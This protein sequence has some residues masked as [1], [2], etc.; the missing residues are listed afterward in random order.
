[1]I[2]HSWVCV[3]PFVY[4]FWF[5][6]KLIELYQETYSQQCSPIGL[7]YLFRTTT[8]FNII[9]RVQG[10]QGSNRIGEVKGLVRLALIG[11][12]EL[13][14]VSTDKDIIDVYIHLY[15]LYVFT[16]ILKVRRI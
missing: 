13:I 11:V 4:I 9:Y 3:P 5:H 14:E 6:L 12:L 2:K 1:M 10:L 15:H 7:L 8:W 16:S